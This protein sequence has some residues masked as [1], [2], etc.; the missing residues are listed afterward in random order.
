MMFKVEGDIPLIH[1]H[2]INK[3][4]AIESVIVLDSIFPFIDKHSEQVKVPFVWPEHI[5]R[6]LKYRPFVSEK[7]SQRSVAYKETAK[8]ILVGKE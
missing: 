7:I 1:K 8:S 4:I 5:N 2:A 6:L 3:E